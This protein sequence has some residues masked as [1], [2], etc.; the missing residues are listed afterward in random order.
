LILFVFSCKENSNDNLSNNELKEIEG[1][2]FDSILARGK[3][4]AITNNTPTSYFIYKG[5]PMGYQFELLSRFAKSINVELEI[6][7]VPSIPDA[8]DSLKL[9]K[10]DIV[11]SGLTVLGDRKKWVDFSTPITQTHQVL[12]QKKPDNYKSMSFTSIEKELLRDVT[13]LARQDVYLEEGS[14]YY[15]RIVNLQDEIGD[16][17]YIHLY[18]GNVD[19]DSLMS[20]VSSGQI[21][22]AIT[23]EYTAKF[24]QSYYPNLD[25]NTPVSFNQNIAWA[26]PKNST[27]LLD[28]IDHWIKQNKNKTSWAYIYNKYFKHNK[29]MNTKAFSGYNLDNGKISPYDAI[30]KTHAEKIGWD[31]KLIAAQISVES[32]FHNDKESWAGAKGLMQIMPATAKYLSP[33]DTSAYL[34]NKNIELGVK[35]DGILY[36]YWDN[37]IPDSIQ[38]IKFALASYNIGKGHILD[39]RR[40]AEKHNLNPNIWDQNVAL[41][42]A[43]LSQRDYYRDDVVRHGYCRGLEAFNYVNRIFFLY[44]NYLNFELPQ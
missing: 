4:I 6:H 19:M 20:M 10:A 31:W 41:M 3:I 17:I 18:S 25:V 12:I 42:I 14:A 13:Q 34:P 43:K 2:S 26:V 39:A 44:Q 22:Y 21:K 9:K 29:N 8:I 36:N 16:S 28:T 32:G 33:N 24:F 35:L 7:I 1:I 27:M 38:A 11:A 37:I 30:I 23:E 15:N 40:L 5:R